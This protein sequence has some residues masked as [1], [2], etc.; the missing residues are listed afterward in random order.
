MDIGSLAGQYSSMIDQASGAKLSSQFKNADYKNATEEELLDACKSFESYFVEKMY[1]EMMESVKAINKDDEKST[2]ISSINDYYQD[3][4]ARQY[5][6]K[7][8]D[9]GGIG[10]AEQL[11]EQMKRNYAIA[12]E[13]NKEE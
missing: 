12:P 11:F 7:L 10:L 4:L 2:Y 6:E 5:A 3:E 13:E 9:Q 8:T 1:K